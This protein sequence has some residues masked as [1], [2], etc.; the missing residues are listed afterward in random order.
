M[1]GLEQIKQAVAAALNAGGL[2]A[3]T[4]FPEGFALRYGSAVAVVGVA[5]AESP[6]L[7]LCDY[8]G[9]TVEPD[10][11]RRVERYARRLTAELSIDVYAPKSVGVGGTETGMERAAE[12]LMTALPSGLRLTG[13]A[14]EQA[15]W[16][17]EN[18]MYLRRGSAACQALF[19]ASAA[20][21]ES[22]TILDFVLKGVISV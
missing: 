20:E 2:A 8:L 13:L 17:A 7:G 12:I 6:G 22:G 14:W 4:E 19:L 16:D 18:G 21:E 5:R 15:A 11:G 9:E 10:T 1:T 3:V